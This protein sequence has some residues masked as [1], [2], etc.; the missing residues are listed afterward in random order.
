MLDRQWM[1]E[2]EDRRDQAQRDWQERMESKR[3]RSSLFWLGLVAT[4]AIIAAIVAAA[5]IQ[6][7]GQ[8]VIN[9]IIEMSTPSISGM[10]DSQ[11]K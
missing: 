5:F 4:A 1:R 11:P 8:P 2:R 9:N 10:E 3:H 7:G 6:R